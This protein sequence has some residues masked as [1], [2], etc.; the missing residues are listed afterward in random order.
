M[1]S[2]TKTVSLNTVLL[3]RKS[4]STK[5]DLGF[6]HNTLQPILYYSQLCTPS[7]IILTTEV[8]YYDHNQYSLANFYLMS[9]GWLQ[10]RLWE[11][12]ETGRL[13]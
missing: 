5:R 8:D 1:D 6:F 4:L 12:R 9:A 10:A 13:F 3:F 7:E 2:V 11:W